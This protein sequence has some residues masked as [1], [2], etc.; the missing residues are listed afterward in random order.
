[1]HVTRPAAALYVA[2]TR[3]GWHKAASRIAG[4]AVELRHPLYAGAVYL[5]P[6]GSL[7]VG[8]NYAHSTPASPAF[9]T[10]LQDY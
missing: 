7:R 5:G 8:R 3:A 9:V 4:R 6:R 2:L 1:M 10:Q